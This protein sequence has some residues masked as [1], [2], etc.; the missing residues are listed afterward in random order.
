M[1]QKELILFLIFVGCEG[2]QGDVGPTGPKGDNG[3]Q[4]IQGPPG[5]NGE[6]G[7]SDK[8]I[9]LDVGA[10]FGIGVLSTDT[11]WHTS[12][13][14]YHTLFRFNKENYIGVDSILF[15]ALVGTYNNAG[16]CSVR[17]INLTDNIPLQSSTISS[18]G[19]G[20]AIKYS[21]N[22]YNELPK[23]EIS[24]G[25]QTKSGTSGVEIYSNR[26][27]LYLFRQ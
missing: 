12:D 2:P 21:V 26:F 3:V 10:S 4:G 19:P 25:I 7:V 18:M 5:S 27:S 22:I 1:K 9:R 17:L 16:L 23:K 6:N 24:I 13:T 8:Q 20:F 15:E 14:L 11:L